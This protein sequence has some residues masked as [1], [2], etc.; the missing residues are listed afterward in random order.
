MPDTLYEAHEDRWAA[1]LCHLGALAPLMGLLVAL[2]V[3]ITQKERS[4]LLRFQAL[5]ALVFQGIAGLAYLLFSI[6]IAFFYFVLFFPMV[7]LSENVGRGG[8][9]FLSIFVILFGL[10]MVVVLFVTLIIVPAYYILA[11][12]AAWRMV[13]GRDFRYPLIGRLVDGIASR[14]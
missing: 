10:F 8:E 3:W 2:V 9:V 6:G 14:P 1:A 4:P 13:K 12:L 5:Q 7:I 11:L